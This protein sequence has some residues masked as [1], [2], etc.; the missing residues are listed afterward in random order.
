MSSARPTRQKSTERIC[1]EIAK[2][3]AAGK[4]TYQLRLELE[5]RSVDPPDGRMRIRPGKAD[6]AL[7][8]PRKLTLR[9]ERRKKAA[10]LIQR[11]LDDESDHDERFWPILK[12]EL[13]GSRL[14]CR[15]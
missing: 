14:R 1:A 4:P 9:R 8:D 3:I 10:D 7:A 6:S 5:S 2:R 12:E 15:E 13:E 11:W